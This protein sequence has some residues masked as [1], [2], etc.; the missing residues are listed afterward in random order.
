MRSKYREAVC[1]KCGKK[2]YTDTN[3]KIYCNERCR[4]LVY[5]HDLWVNSPEFR[6]KKNAQNNAN[7]KRKRDR[8]KIEWIIEQ[9]AKIRND[10][11]NG[12][13]T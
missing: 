11:G 7:R 2:F 1:P 4:T 12:N 6:A 8:K 9:E 13:Q 10:A 5:L 3:S